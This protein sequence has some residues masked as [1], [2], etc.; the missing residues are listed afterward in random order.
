VDLSDILHLRLEP[1]MAINPRN[2]LS[3]TI[4]RLFAT[5]WTGSS[6]AASSGNRGE[7]GNS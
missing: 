6:A 3:D 7:G 2:S 1:G 5:N 4:R